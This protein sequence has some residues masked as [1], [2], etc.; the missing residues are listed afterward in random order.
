[1]SHTPEVRRQMWHGCR[2]MRVSSLTV[3]DRLPGS[4]RRAPRDCSLRT[5]QGQPQEGASHPLLC[6]GWGGG[7]EVCE[8][9]SGGGGEVEIMQLVSAAAAS[10]EGCTPL[11]RSSA[12]PQ[13][14]MSPHNP[15]GPKT[16]VARMMVCRVMRLYLT[17]RSLDCRKC[18]ALPRKQDSLGRSMMIGDDEKRHTLQHGSVRTPHR[19]PLRRRQTCKGTLFTV[20]CYLIHSVELITPCWQA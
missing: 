14:E 16:D 4:A 7:V 5:G 19:V 11:A 15:G 18:R 20:P 17:H 12:S 3:H 1:M 9:G 13:H 2:V 6:G 10:A 8:C